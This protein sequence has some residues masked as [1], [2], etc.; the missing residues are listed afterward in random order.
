M[1][2]CG[3]QTYNPPFLS[4]IIGVGVLGV[5]TLTLATPQPDSGQVLD[6]IRQPSQPTLHTPPLQIKKQ[7]LEPTVKP[8]GPTVI[9]ES[10]HFSGNSVLSDQALQA[11]IQD[12]IGKAHDLSS[13]QYLAQRIT[14]FYHDQDYPFGLA[15]LP[16]QSIATG[17]LEIAIVEGKFGEIRFIGP[18]KLTQSIPSRIPNIATGEVIKGQ[19]LERVIGLAGDLPGININ[20]VLMPGKAVGTGDLEIDI[21]ETERYTASIGIDNHGGRYTGTWRTHVDASV[22]RLATLGDKLDLAM[23]LTKELWYGNIGYSLPISNTGAKAYARYTQTYY[24]LGEEFEELGAKGKARIGSLGVDYPLIRSQNTNLY[25]D[26]TFNHKRLEDRPSKLYA[27]NQKSS[28]SLTASLRFDHRDRLFGGGLTWSNISLTPGKLNLDQTLSSIDRTTAKTE[29][30]FS[31]FNLEL[32]RLQHLNRHWSLYG[33]I[34]GQWSDVNLDSSEGM[35]LGGPNG[36]R[37]YPSGEAFGDR[38]WLSQLELRYQHKQLQPYLF[39]DA[40]SMESNAQPWEPGDNHRTL[41]GA[42]LGLRAS[43]NNWQLNMVSAW[44]TKG[45][46][47]ESDTKGGEPRIWASAQYHF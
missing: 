28:D 15:Y 35:S 22:N 43:L 42:G 33:H 34:S 40:G 2:R 38:G 17:D 23:M 5:S 14:Q 20:P 27:T 19:D 18:D 44:R 37:A 16:P 39:Y 41:A 9:V 46:T 8:G 25:A 47:P 30:R 7:T 36:V 13:L 26:L 12:A 21:H 29:G 24:Q 3:L 32:A 31:K 10:V 11:V 6:E 4:F 45:G 1:N